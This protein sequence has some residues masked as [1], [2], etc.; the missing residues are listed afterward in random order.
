ML[1]PESEND[2]EEAY[3]YNFK[4]WVK[5]NPDRAYLYCQHGQY[6]GANGCLKQ[7]L[8]NCKKCKEE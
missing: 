3:Q 1:V 7:F 4:K 5:N 6:W 2:Q 8:K